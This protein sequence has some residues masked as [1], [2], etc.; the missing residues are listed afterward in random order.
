[1]K[2]TW[3]G[4]SCVYLEGSARVLMDPYDGTCG[5]YVLPPLPADVYTVSHEHYDHNFTGAV[6]NPEAVRARYGMFEK[7]VRITSVH[8]WHDRVQ[9]RQWGPNEVFI[10][11][12]DGYRIAHLGDLGQELDCAQLATLGRVDILFIPVGGIYS[13]DAAEAAEVANAVDA[14]LTFP[15]HYYTP[16]LDTAAFEL[17]PGLDVFIEKSGRRAIMLDSNVV[18]TDTDKLPDGSIVVFHLD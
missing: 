1:M 11:D 10:L 5:G 4:L 6:S 3:Y 13:I 17:E 18:C 7:G 16:H 14:R 12:M 2:I 9:G 15:I 8:T